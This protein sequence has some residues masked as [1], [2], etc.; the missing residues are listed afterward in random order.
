MSNTMLLLLCVLGLCYGFNTN[1]SVR[2]KVNHDYLPDYEIPQ[3]VYK[4]VFKHNKVPKK[5]RI[6]N[7][8]NKKEYVSEFDE[9]YNTFV[10]LQMPLGYLQPINNI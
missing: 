4:D 8:E 1:G 5:I 6:N 2:V 3:W 9:T 10:K 7:N